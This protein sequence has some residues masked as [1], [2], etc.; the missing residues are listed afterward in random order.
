M[1]VSL[2]PIFVNTSS[3]S[4]IDS[5][6]SQ[7]EQHPPI[8]TLSIKETIEL[9]TLVEHQIYAESYK[10]D[11]KPPSWLYILRNKE[12]RLDDA[13]SVTYDPQ[14]K[15]LFQ[16]PKSIYEP[17]AK[18]S[19]NNT[20][21]KSDFEIYDYKGKYVV[22][23]GFSP[24]LEIPKHT[25]VHSDYLLAIDNDLKK[26]PQP[27]EDHL[28]NN[29]VKL[30]LG[31]TEDDTY[32]YYR[33]DFAE[34]DCKKIIDPTKPQLE[35]INNTWVDNRLYANLGGIY[36]SNTKQALMPQWVRVYGSEDCY[37]DLS[38]DLNRVFG[39]ALHEM[40]HAFDYTQPKMFSETKEFKKAYEADIQTLNSD[41]DKL[42]KQH[43]TD[44]IK[45]WYTNLRNRQ[46]TFAELFRAFFD[47]MK[48]ESKEL[49][50]KLTPNSAKCIKDF[51]FSIY[52]INIP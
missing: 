39:I 4:S 15:T 12:C 25:C 29:G 14:I 1:Q 45:A 49:L 47:G 50:I 16:K 43:G 40:G 27:I 6:K 37:Y 24:L 7:E 28:V 22:T 26:L 34:R 23:Y 52:E 20:A 32:Y 17:I 46:E 2:F 44:T 30:I 5:K 38:T 41:K 11:V 19:T 18:V 21:L 42:E 10:V 35:F 8:P 9:K 36:L 3:T 13:F 48:V 51:L 31:Q 33:S